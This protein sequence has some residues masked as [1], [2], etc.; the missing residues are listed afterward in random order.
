[1]AGSVLGGD[2]IKNVNDS[3]PQLIQYFKKTFDTNRTPF[4]RMK[5]HFLTENLDTEFLWQFFRPLSFLS[6]AEKRALIRSAIF[7]VLQPA[8][9]RLNPATVTTIN[10]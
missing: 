6:P 1:M 5:M 9:H 2:Q 10:V 3:Y 8:G 4:D 7:D